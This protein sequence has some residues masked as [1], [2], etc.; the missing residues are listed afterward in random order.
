MTTTE[1]KRAG[2]GQVAGSRFIVRETDDGLGIVVPLP[3]AKVLVYALGLLLLY[4]AGFLPVLRD[5]LTEGWYTLWLVAGTLGVGALAWRLFGT[6]RLFITDGALV[7]S[8][9][10]N[11]PGRRAV[12]LPGEIT[13]ARI[14]TRYVPTGDRAGRMVLRSTIS[15]EARGKTYDFGEDMDADERSVVYHAMLRHL[16]PEA[17]EPEDD[18]VDE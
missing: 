10:P 18:A 14:R 15:F 5:R 9:W 8:R 3:R 7:L 13:R 12:F 1:Q 11:L 6:E 4:L 2:V 17:R 16:P